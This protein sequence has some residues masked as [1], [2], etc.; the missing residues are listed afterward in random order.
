[1]GVQW[2]EKS[3]QH[4]LLIKSYTSM[5]LCSTTISACAKCLII[6]VTRF[7][8]WTRLLSRNVGFE[9]LIQLGTFLCLTA[10]QLEE[11]GSSKPNKAVVEVSSGT[12][13]SWVSDPWNCHHMPESTW[14]WDLGFHVTL[15]L[16]QTRSSAVTIG[17][18][19]A[20]LAILHCATFPSVAYP[21]CMTRKPEKNSVN[22]M[23]F[24]KI[25]A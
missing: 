4:W 21:R 18:S 20:L 19:S 6:N 8:A 17:Y 2:K 5:I 13:R 9:I 12:I 23:H 22:S 14:L 10:I 1:M 3:I 25:K 11:N 7:L 15:S 24:F 16:S